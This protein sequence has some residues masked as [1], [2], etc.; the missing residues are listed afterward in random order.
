MNLPQDGMLLRI[1]VGETDH[2]KGKA[3]YEQIVLKARELNLAGATVVRGI[4]GFGAD[5]RMHT[6]KLLRLSE[7]LPVVIEIVDTEEKL[8]A[9]LPFLDEVVEEGLITLEKVRVI[10]YRHKGEG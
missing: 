4:M 1:F 8:T 5:S 6:A 2:Y 10:K 3:L 7:D 9:L